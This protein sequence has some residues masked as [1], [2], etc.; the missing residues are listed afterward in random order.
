[1]KTAIKRLVAVVSAMALIFVS[2]M[3]VV[4]SDGMEPDDDEVEVS[5]NV[6]TGA[7][8]LTSE[9]DAVQAT[10]LSLNAKA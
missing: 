9:A 6:L 8:V 10:A 5:A 7:E 1:M 3:I 4:A 2:W